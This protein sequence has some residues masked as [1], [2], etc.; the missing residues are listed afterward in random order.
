RATARAFDIQPG[1]HVLCCLPVRFIAGKMMV[2]RALVN[3]WNLILARPDAEALRSMEMSVDFAAMTPYQVEQS[4]VRFPNR[5][6]SIGKL[7]IGGAATTP[8]LESQLNDFPVRAW[9]TYGMTE[10]ITHVA[11][12]ELG[13]KESND[14]FQALHGI[15]FTVTEEGTLRI[16]ADHLPNGAI[17]TN[18]LVALLSPTQFKLLGRIDDVINSGGVKLHPEGIERKLDGILHRRYYIAAQPDSTFG[19]RP[20]WVIEG[21][22]L[23]VEIEAALLDAAAL[24]LEKYEIPVSIRYLNLFETTATGKVKRILP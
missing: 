19:Q 5:F 11:A 12:R 13:K 4:M 18:D 17:T 1:A 15:E 22:P 7:I 2:V 24:R 14:V 20:C 23:G 16:H 21:T 8:L 6:Q 9:A 10:T 3:D